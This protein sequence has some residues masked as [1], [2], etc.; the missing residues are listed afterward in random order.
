LHLVSRDCA[1]S[2]QAVIYIFDLGTLGLTSYFL[3]PLVQLRLAEDPSAARAEIA[4]K[5]QADRA[6]IAPKTQA[7]R[8]EIA[9]KT[10]ADRA[11]IAP[12][13]QAEARGRGVEID[14]RDSIENEEFSTG[15]QRGFSLRSFVREEVQLSRDT[16]REIEQVFRSYRAFW[17]NE[18]VGFFEIP[19]VKFMVHTAFFLQH[20]TLFIIIMPTALQLRDE[21][22]A[23]ERISS[24]AH[25]STHFYTLLPNK[26]NAPILIEFLIY[27]YVVGRAVEE[28][29]QVWLDDL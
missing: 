15:S 17:V 19:R 10:Q 1:S 16:W 18:W 5:T 2:S 26:L 27:A 4:P 24:W 9:P 20:A 11:E 22:Q 21:S 28:L 23:N 13:T 25:R 7:D 29:Q 12:K 3:P 14:Y 6:E 8:A